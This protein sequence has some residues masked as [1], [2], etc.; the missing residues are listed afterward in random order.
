MTVMKTSTKRFKKEYQEFAYVVS[1]D[2]YA[3]LRQINGFTNLLLDDM[4]DKLSE[5]QK[6]I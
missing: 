6:N 3:P 4:D 5:D 1:H 2:L